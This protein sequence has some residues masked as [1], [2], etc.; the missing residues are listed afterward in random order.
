MQLVVV[1]CV[2]V[3]TG[4]LGA[5]VTFMYAQPSRILVD[6]DVDTDD[7][8]ALF[9]LLKQNR[10]EFDLQVFLSAFVWNITPICM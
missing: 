1:L 10:K 3:L 4:S 6:T 5:S 7:V 9:Y 2:V 8:F